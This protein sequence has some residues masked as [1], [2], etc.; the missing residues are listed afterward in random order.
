MNPAILF[1]LLLL[2]AA[3]VMLRLSD[4]AL[5]RLLGLSNLLLWAPAATLLTVLNWRV[6]LGQQPTA[7]GYTL[8]IIAAI[9]AIFLAAGQLSTVLRLAFSKKK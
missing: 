6:E 3:A 1:G 7:L 8:V 2:L 5:V 4:R 9:G